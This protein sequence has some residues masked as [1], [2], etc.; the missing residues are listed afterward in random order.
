M[1]LGY[2]NPSVC[3]FNKYDNFSCKSIT[4]DKNRLF[5]CD[6][7]AWHLE[8]QSIIDLLIGISNTDKSFT[9]IVSIWFRLSRPSN[10]PTLQEKKMAKEA[11]KPQMFRPHKTF[12]FYHFHG[13]LPQAWQKSYRSFYNKYNWYFWAFSFSVHFMITEKNSDAFDESG[14]WK[15]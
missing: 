11:R 13:C 12:I 14:W 4:H 15:L 2:F 3:I 1:V 6:K 9:W 8:L 10:V 5:V 7:E